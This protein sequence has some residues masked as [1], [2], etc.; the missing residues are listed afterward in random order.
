MRAMALQTDREVVR[1][2]RVGVAHRR[3]RGTAGGRLVYLRDMVESITG[4][5]NDKA[6]PVAPRIFAPTSTHAFMQHLFGEDMHAKRVKSLAGATTG[7]L[8]CATMSIH[9]IGRA[10]AQVAHIEA[11]SGVKI[12]DRLLSNEGIDFERIAPAWVRWV[13][14]PRKEIVAVLDW[15]EYDSDDHTTLGMYLVTRH[16]RATPLLWK[17][18]RKSTLKG[19]RTGYEHA[20][21]EWL[22]RILDTSV[23]VTLLADRGF[24]DRKLYD[25]LLALGWDFVIRFRECIQVEL[26]DGPSAPASEWVPKGG[27]AKMLTDAKVTSERCPIPAVVVAHGKKMQS[28]WCLATS[29]S[30]K[31][32]AE[33]VKLYGKRFTIEETFRDQKDLH[34]GMGL[35]A[36][37]IGRGD[38]RD[39]MLL[40]GALAQVLLTLLGAAAES[41]GWSLNSNTEKRRQ[42]SLFNQGLHWYGAIPEMREERLRSLMH[43]YAKILHEHAG[44]REIFGVI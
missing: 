6:P 5:R 3:R 28:P 16:G 39:R 36:T 8:R 11:K 7:L 10:Y 15:T 2:G 42:L 32:A 19:R 14:G 33:V 23:D 38:R 24:G 26:G 17:T 20:M 22:H 30:T 1:A 13:V 40:L 34:F 21:V 12:I 18:V 37:H 25:L 44:L 4:S 41:S 31:T 27:R 9:A 29:L 43:A 35:A